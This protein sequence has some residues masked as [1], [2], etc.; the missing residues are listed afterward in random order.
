MSGVAGAGRRDRILGG[1]MFVRGTC[2]GGGA[3]VQWK[4]YATHNKMQS[5]PDC[6]CINGD[7]GGFVRDGFGAGP[8][9]QLVAGE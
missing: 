9:I 2:Q 6:F 7:G 3:A 4:Y 5:G 8:R 1:D